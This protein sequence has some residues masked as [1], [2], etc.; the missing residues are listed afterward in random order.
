LVRSLD[1]TARQEPKADLA[2]AYVNIAELALR[3]GRPARATSIV[4]EGLRRYPQDAR[5]KSLRN[6]SEIRR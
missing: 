1:L 6:S 4:D 3:M 2:A 5:L